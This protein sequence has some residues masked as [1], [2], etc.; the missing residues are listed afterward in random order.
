MP[1][2]DLFAN[3]GMHYL[4]RRP[5]EILTDDHRARTRPAGAARTGSCGAAARSTS[6]SRR[7]RGRDAL[8][9]ERPRR[10]RR[11]SCSARSRR[12]RWRA[13]RAEALLA[14]ETLTDERIAAAA[15]AAYAVAKPMDNTD[16]ELVWRKKMSPP[17]GRPTR[18]AKCA[19][20]TCEPSAH[21]LARQIL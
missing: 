7:W 11:G 5:D 13:P 15:D 19:A 10:G 9:G 12:G 6:P 3:D 4:T 2:A 18:C 20:T 21:R 16:F 14:G 1:V 17:A 8:D